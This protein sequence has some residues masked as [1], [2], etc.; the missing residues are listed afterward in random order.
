M[1]KDPRLVERHAAGRCQIGRDVRPGADARSERRQAGILRVEIGGCPRECVA[2]ALPELKQ[3]QI[4]IG[5]RVADAVRGPGRVLRQHA[6]EI[7]EVFGHA[8]RP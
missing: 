1:P 7:A 5:Q 3:R 8:L 6:L 4:D 2:Q